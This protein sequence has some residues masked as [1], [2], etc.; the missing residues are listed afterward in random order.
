MPLFSGNGKVPR[1]DEDQLRRFL[2]ARQRA[3]Q[4]TFR[5]RLLITAAVLVAGSFLCYL[6]MV[7]LGSG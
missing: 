1:R 7:L 3:K 4:E 5:V 2:S 6:V